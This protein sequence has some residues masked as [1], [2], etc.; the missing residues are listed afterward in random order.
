MVC[1]HGRSV[2]RGGM[3]G[4]ASRSRRRDEGEVERDGRLGGGSGV[5]SVARWGRIGM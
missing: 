1:V 5:V 4:T 3:D 2:A